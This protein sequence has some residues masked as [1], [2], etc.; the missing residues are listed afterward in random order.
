MKLHQGLVKVSKYIFTGTIDD[1]DQRKI[2]HSDIF[3]PGRINSHWYKN[4]R[5]KHEK[6]MLLSID[7]INCVEPFCKTDRIDYES[8]VVIYFKHGSDPRINGI[9]VVKDTLDTFLLKIRKA[10][11]NI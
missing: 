7:S 2:N 3:L 9:F 8:Y 11:W 6:D 1:E 5:L 4:A 10:E